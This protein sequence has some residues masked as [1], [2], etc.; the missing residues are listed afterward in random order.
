MKEGIEDA[1]EEEDLENFQND[2]G[3]IVKA[4]TS[5][6]RKDPGDVRI[7]YIYYGDLLDVA[8]AVL[9]KNP[10]ADTLSI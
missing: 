1:T 9:K 3:D 10:E 5:T 7:N 6:K 2:L 8:F 4:N